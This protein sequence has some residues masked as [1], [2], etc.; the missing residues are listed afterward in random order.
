VRDFDAL[1][2]LARV[3]ANVLVPRVGA[4]T[5]TSKEVGVMF[6]AAKG[7]PSSATTIPVAKEVP[8]TA[9]GVG[10]PSSIVEGVIW[11][12]VGVTRFR[13]EPLI[14]STA[15]ERSSLSLSG[16]MKFAS[17]SPSG[18]AMPSRGS[19]FGGSEP[20]NE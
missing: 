11:V 20:S 8:L 2:P 18:S 15:S 6:V 17:P 7:F 9:S 13:S 16:S 19:R 1:S 3:T 10:C 12:M 5:V 4:V 14:S